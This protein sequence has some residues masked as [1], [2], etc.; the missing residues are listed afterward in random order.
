[1]LDLSHLEWVFNPV[2]KSGKYHGILIGVSNGSPMGKKP[3]DDEKKL[4]AKKETNC[5]W[6]LVLKNRRAVVPGTVGLQFSSLSCLYF[7]T[8]APKDTE[9]AEPK[10]ICSVPV[11]RNLCSSLLLGRW[12]LGDSCCYLKI[13]EEKDE[14][15]SNYCLLL[16]V[17]CRR[18]PA[19]QHRRGSRTC[20]FSRTPSHV[21]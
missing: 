10:L 21:T 12:I 5:G 1:M 20:Q 18:V 11:D 3:W 7:H 13:S 2:L 14:C 8:H 15:C 16:A 17:W 4:E 9:R 19:I 6:G